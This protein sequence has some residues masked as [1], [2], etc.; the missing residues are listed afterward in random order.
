MAKCLS[1]HSEIPGTGKKLGDDMVDKNLAFVINDMI[2]TRMMVKNQQ[3]VDAALQNPTFAAGVEKGL[4]ILTSDRLE[5]A[6]HD[7]EIAIIAQLISPAQG[8]GAGG[9]GSHGEHGESEASGDRLDFGH[10]AHKPVATLTIAEK[11]YLTSLFSAKYHYKEEYNR[12]MNL[13]TGEV[14][15]TRIDY[16]VPITLQTKD[17][18]PQVKQVNEELKEKYYNLMIPLYQTTDQAL[19]HQANSVSDLDRSRMTKNAAKMGAI[20]AAATVATLATGGAG[21]LAGA[22]G[23]LT[24]MATKDILYGH[25]YDPDNMH[26]VS[27][28]MALYGAS[29]LS[30]AAVGRLTSIESVHSVIHQTEHGVKHGLRNLVSERVAHHSASGIVGTAESFIAGKLIK[31]PFKG[32]ALQYLTP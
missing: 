12:K 30:G 15:S 27:K 4:G 25:G 22:A 19:A 20:A 3:A 1:G 32:A 9:E 29:I 11:T 10:L 26:D 21:A 17:I 7:P 24:G 28:F 6:Q 23:G 18:I 14:R 8:H 2:Q 5:E 13:P 16:N 31:D